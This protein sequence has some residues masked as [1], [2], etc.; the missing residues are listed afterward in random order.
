V[1]YKPGWRPG[2]WSA[3]CDVCGFRFHSDKLQKRWD[4]L[5][6]CSK[7][8]ETKHPSD[9]F[10]L[11]GENVNPPWTRPEP[12]DTYSFVCYVWALSSYTDLAEADCARAD[13]ATLPYS[14]LLETKLGTAT[15]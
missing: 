10:R 12:S 9:F 14:I 13:S 4:G 7:D 1:S 3:I 15:H 11:K 2:R 5:M 8:Y 6:V